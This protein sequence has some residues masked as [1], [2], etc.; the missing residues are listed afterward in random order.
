MNNVLDLF[1]GIGGFSL[2][3]ERT[4]GFKTIAFCEIEPFPRKVL[5][6][7]WPDVPI[8]EDVRTLHASDIDGTVDVICGGFPCQPFSSASRGR[9]KEKSMWPEMLNAVREF[10]PLFVVAEN[11]SKP[12]MIKAKEDLKKHGYESS[13]FQL[14]AGQFG[15]DHERVRWWLCAHPD[16]KGQF[17]SAFNAKVAELQEIYRS[18]WTWENY[19]QSLRVS[20]G[21]SHRVDRLKALGNSVVPQ[22]V[23]MIGRAILEAQSTR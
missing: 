16:N 18:V 4:G 21:V 13:V 15:A 8:F 12:P 20:N 22:V 7:H 3:L 23:E 10:S 9:I 11:V 14:S 2:G 17:F 1:S 6:K 5:A 19:A